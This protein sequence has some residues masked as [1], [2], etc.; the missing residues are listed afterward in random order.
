MSSQGRDISEMLSWM[1][2]NFSIEMLASIMNMLNRRTTPQDEDD[3]LVKHVIFSPLV[4]KHNTSVVFGESDLQASIQ[5]RHGS[6]WGK[7]R[8][9]PDNVR[10]YDLVHDNSN[11]GG[12]SFPSPVIIPTETSIG[13]KN[14]GAAMTDGMSYMAISDHAWLN[15]TDK[16]MLNGY[17]YLK[18]NVSSA[19][20][21]IHKGTNQWGLKTMSGNILRFEVEI[22]GIT[23][24]L[25]YVYTP[26]TWIHF[27]AQAKSGSQE[28]WV[29]NVLQDSDVKTGSIGTNS[30]ALG[31]F[32]T[33]AG[34]SLLASGSALS[35]I[36]LA[37]GFG[38]SAWISSFF[39]DSILDYDDG[40]LDT[41]E[42]I[43]TVPFL[44][45]LQEMPNAFAGM[46][47]G[48]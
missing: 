26:D 24:N 30:T 16:I 14:M 46:F 7:R 38:D 23:Y 27:V 10:A 3:A 39:N 47:I 9:I 21:I 32:G 37:N 29:N 1:G 22:G 34:A 35:W 13:R 4:D 12:I 48:T 28:L 41:P 17:L 18:A 11:A 6:G 45:S 40:I 42:E 43:T 36:S 19:Q 2:G 20:Y 44:G 15:V 33:V 5:L 31:I 25:D 8:F